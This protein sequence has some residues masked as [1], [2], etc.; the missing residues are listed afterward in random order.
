MSQP[1][2]DRPFR[3]LGICAKCGAWNPLDFEPETAGQPANQAVIL[4]AWWTS[5]GRVY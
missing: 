1:D 4:T 3:L 2:Q 5:D